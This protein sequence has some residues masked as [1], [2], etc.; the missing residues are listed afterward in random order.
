MSKSA[1]ITVCALI[2]S[3]GG[4]VTAIFI[5]YFL[6]LVLPAPENDLGDDVGPGPMMVPLLYLAGV[7]IVYATAFGGG[8]MGAMVGYLN[9]RLRRSA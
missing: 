5:G 1:L 6:I 8:A 3:Y 9:A 4:A 7:I 2:G